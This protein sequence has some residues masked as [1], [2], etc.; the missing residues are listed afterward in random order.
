MKPERAVRGRPR[1]RSLVRFAG[2]VLLL[3]APIGAQAGGAPAGPRGPGVPGESEGSGAGE[4]PAAPAPTEG[5]GLAQLQVGH[6]VKAKGQRES[7][8]SFVVSEIVVTEPDDQQA[9]IAT[10]QALP[11]PTRFLMLGQE[12]HVSGRT[13]WSG[14][15]EGDPT[16]KRV[17]VQGHYHGPRNFAAR[18]VQLRKKG[19]D[20]IEGRIDELRRVSNGVEFR[21]MN[22]DIFAPT[23]TAVEV[24]DDRPLGEI[25]LAPRVEFE[26]PFRRRLDEEENVR[27]Q[28]RLGPHLSLG[29]QLE[30]KA[31]RE[32]DY[33][34]DDTKRRS[35]TDIELSAR[36]EVLWEP[37]SSFYALGSF[38]HR[39]RWRD[40]E[41]KGVSNLGNSKV[42]ELFGYWRGM[43]GSRFDLQ[44]GRQDFDERREWLYDENLDAVRLIRT[45]QSA[46]LELS[47]STQFQGNS[48]ERQTL[49]TIVYLSNGRN[50]KHLAAYAINRFQKDTEYGTH[51]GVRALGEWLPETRSWL[52]IAG[53]TGRRND[54]ATLSFGFDGG[55]TWS[56][57][58]IGPAYLTAGWAY[59]SGDPSTA[60]GNDNNFRQTG[61]QDNNDKW[62]GVT[63]FRYYGELVDPEL[64]N[65]SIL[66][67]G[68][69][70]RIGRRN[71]I[72][73]VWHKF[74]QAVAAP[75]LFN[76]NLRRV[77]DGVHRDLGWETDVILG[78]QQLEG[79]F[80]EIV[81]GY[82]EPG[83]AF[84]GADPAWLAKFQ[85]RYSF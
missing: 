26:N 56:P 79:W 51:F 49:N 21:I 25:E 84:P 68:I 8:G 42:A 6:W 44:V 43:F 73:L 12:V 20:R 85:L 52:E 2:A 77:P 39:Q 57:D 9:I 19:R 37:S 58:F 55:G 74:D 59:G 45:G 22:F 35:R 14:L 29:G 11:G 66:S 18:K 28:I 63:S 10:A 48:Q 72:D 80:L 36:A 16:G 83:S 75:S 3:V 23:G 17:K 4:V 67:L 46:R 81:G 69:G 76:T 30:T 27:G 33:N 82:F 62:G 54:V 64:S 32:E 31:R 40:D 5:T 70:T 41:R 47:L 7:D 61:F 60:D 13:S 71:S 1:G 65:L 53:H 50:D 78:S 15:A 24:E 38:R 34:L